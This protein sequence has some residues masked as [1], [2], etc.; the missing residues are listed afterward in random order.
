MTRLLPSALLLS[1]LFAA[2]TPAAADATPQ[3]PT[4]VRTGSG[5]AAPAEKLIC[6]RRLKTGTLASY[7]KSCH[8]RADW[9]RIGDR[10]RETWAE[11][12]GSKGSTHGN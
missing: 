4:A 8:T 12:Q 6:K 1:S 5:A 3:S 2:P 10:W 7:E 11:M 9:E